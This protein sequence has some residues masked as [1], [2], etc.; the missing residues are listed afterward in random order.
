MVR[1]V[2]QLCWLVLAVVWCTA[3]V[4]RVVRV[5]GRLELPGAV[6]WCTVGGMHVVCGVLLV[7]VVH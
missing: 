1:A 2:V 4:H 6:G 3:V 7:W 5:D